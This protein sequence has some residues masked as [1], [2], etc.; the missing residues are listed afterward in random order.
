MPDLAPR[1]APRL[2]PYWAPHPAPQEHLIPPTIEPYIPDLPQNQPATYLIKPTN[3]QDQ[4]DEFLLFVRLEHE[5]E[6]PV[7]ENGL[8]STSDWNDVAEAFRR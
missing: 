1:S 8:D 6:K 7:H 4:L 2:A 5:L 3:L